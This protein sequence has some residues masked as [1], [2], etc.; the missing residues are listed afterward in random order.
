MK[1]KM[2]VS[3]P[4]YLHTVVN[5]QVS[6]KDHCYIASKNKNKSVRIT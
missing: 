3:S 5:Y 4:F 1:Q 2:Q 6:Q